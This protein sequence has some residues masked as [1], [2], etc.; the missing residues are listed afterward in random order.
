[1]ESLIPILPWSKTKPTPEVEAF[2]QRPAFDERAEAAAA[3][4]LADIRAR[5]LPAVLDACRTFDQADL[6]PETIRVT[7]AE[8]DAAEAA[9]DETVKR[10]ILQAAER[11]E[12]FAKAGL[13][14]DWTMPTPKG[15]KLGERYHP[16]DRVGMYIPGGTAPL[17]STS[18]MTVVLAKAAGVKEIV[19][20][21]PSRGGL[22]VSAPSS[23]H[24]ASRAQPKF[25]ALVAF[26][27]SA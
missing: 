5:G 3:T 21:T 8:L 27:P 19:A 22:T 4:C 20:C 24:Y 7:E 23:M 15:G 18:I 25:I 10:A 17:A 14:P 6:T 2:L 26:S 1:M 11:V 16:M 13:R 9:C 12:A